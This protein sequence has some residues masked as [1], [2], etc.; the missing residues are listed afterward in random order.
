MYKYISLGAIQQFVFN[1]LDRW[2]GWFMIDSV[3]VWFLDGQEAL[4]RQTFGKYTL[5]MHKGFTKVDVHI[6]SVHV[7]L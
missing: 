6:S 2:C 7:K 5:H 3:D 1:W 4:K